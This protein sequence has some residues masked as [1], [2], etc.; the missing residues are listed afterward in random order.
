MLVLSLGLAL[1]S[2]SVAGTS[3]CAMPTVEGRVDLDPTCIYRTSILI[4]RPALIDCHGAV[5]DGGGQLA[6]GIRI[7]S[8]GEPLHGV[9]IR[10]CT[11]RN[12]TKLGIGV[13][14]ALADGDKL[15][16]PGTGDAAAYE[17]RTP[18]D[19]VIA[20]TRVEGIGG[21]GIYIDDHV[22]GTRM[23][24]V[25]V[26][27]AQGAGIYLEHDSRNA[28][29]EHATVEGN[30]RA[31]AVG[32]QPGMAI[33]ASQGNVVRD[34]TFR[35]NGQGGIFL[36]RNCGERVGIDPQAVPRETGANGNL[37]EGNSFDETTGIR[38]A[39]RMSRNLRA[40]QCGRKPYYDAGGVQI[41]L[42][43]AR[44]N[45]IRGN[46][47]R[48]G[49]WGVIVEDDDN[50]IE[51][52]TFIGKFQGAPVLIGTKYRALVLHR[53]VTGT[54]VSGNRIDGDGRIA[55]IGGSRP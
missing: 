4:R 1:S 49:D 17:A 3:Q 48:A 24:H 27:G 15:R 25:I 5:I 8:N 37:I 54:R 19:T 50:V 18:S 11:V 42:D 7:D 21:V 20:N 35:R 33:D 16:A 43:E 14:W 45:I 53:P 38:V 44:H 26:R 55:W 10:N 31:G 32:A 34:S 23:Q 30:G 13:G 51:G 29:I 40:M 9:Q 39:A 12:F 52:N 47:I 41:V 22:V 2:Q 6:T 46:E 36:Y 28:T